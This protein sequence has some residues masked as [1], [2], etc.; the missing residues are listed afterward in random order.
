VLEIARTMLR[1][2]EALDA[3]STGAAQ[4]KQW[5]LM[6]TALAAAIAEYELGN[7]AAAEALASSSV[8]SWRAVPG[9]GL[10]HELIGAQAKILQAQSI[11][12]Q[13][14]GAESMGILGPLLRFLRD[15]HAR[16]HENRMLDFQFAHAL[17]AAALAEPAER[18]A[19]LAEASAILDRLPPTMNRWKTGERLRGW[20]AE[21]RS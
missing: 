17:Y 12:R 11:A 6:W 21:A 7:F 20:I 10:R 4:A 9:A 15:Q 8:A 13:G 5:A 18:D 16:P 2:T 1:D 3:P 19:R 14:R